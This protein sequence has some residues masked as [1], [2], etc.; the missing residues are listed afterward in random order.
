M[1]DINREDLIAMQSNVKVTTSYSK[2]VIPPQEKIQVVTGEEGLE[3]MFS[4]RAKLYRFDAYSDSW[5][6][7]GFGDVKLLRYPKIGQ[8]RVFMRGEQIKTLCANHNIHT[9][10]ELK[11]NVVSDHSWLWYTPA[12]Y[13]EG[14]AKPENLAIM[15]K[16]AEIAEQFKEV[17]NRL[18]EALSADICPETVPAG[19]Q[20][21]A[22]CPAIFSAAATAAVAN[23]HDDDDDADDD[24][25]DDDNDLCKICH[26]QNKELN[27]KCIACKS[28]KPA[29]GSLQSLCKTEELKETTTNAFVVSSVEPNTS[30][31]LNKGL[32]S[33]ASI[34]QSPEKN[35]KESRGSIDESLRFTSTKGEYDEEENKDSL[36][37]VIPGKKL[38][39]Q[40]PTGIFQFGQQDAYAPLGRATSCAESVNP[41]YQ[42]TT[43]SLS[44][45]TP[46]PQS[47]LQTSQMFSQPFS[48][49]GAFTSNSTPKLD[50]SSSELLRRLAAAKEQKDSA[51][52]E[53][54]T[55]G[56]DFTPYVVN[57]PGDEVSLQK[58]TNV[59]I[60]ISEESAHEGS[61]YS[62]T[63]GEDDK[64]ENE[65]SLDSP[66][67]MPPKQ[68]PQTHPPFSPS[69]GKLL[70]SP[71]KPFA[72]Q[73]VQTDAGAGS[74]SPR[75]FGRS[76]TEAVKKSLNSSQFTFGAPSSSATEKSS[77]NVPVDEKQVF[78][79][80]SQV[81]STTT[82]STSQP[83]VFA[84]FGITTI[85]NK[86]NTPSF[87]L[88]SSNTTG[89]SP[90]SF[91]VPGKADTAPAGGRSVFGGSTPEQAGPSMSFGFFNS[92]SF[93]GFDLDLSNLSTSS[94]KMDC[95]VGE[96]CESDNQ[97]T[98]TV[99]QQCQITE[100]QSSFS[101]DTPTHK[102]KTSRQ[103]LLW[104]QPTGTLQFGHLDAYAPLGGATTWAESVNPW[105]QT[106]IPALD[107][108]TSQPHSVL[109]TSQPSSLQDAFT[110]N[111]RPE[112]DFSSSELLRRPAANTE[113]QHSTRQ[114]S[115]TGGYN[116]A[117]GEE[118]SLQGDTKQTFPITVEECDNNM[119]EVIIEDSEE[120]T[121]ESSSY[122]TSKGKD[123]EE[124]NEVSCQFSSQIPPMR[125]TRSHP[126]FSPIQGKLLEKPVVFASIHSSEGK[127]GGPD[128]L[129]TY[130]AG[131]QSWEPTSPL[132]GTKKQDEDC[133]LVYEVRASIVD[134]EK[135]SRLWLP[136]NFFNYT[137][138][139]V[140]AGCF[141][142]RVIAK[143][144]AKLWEKEYKPRA[145]M[146]HT[147]ENVPNPEKSEN[148]NHLFGESSAINQLTFSILKPKE[149]D[150]WG[151]SQ[152]STTGQGE[153]ASEVE[154]ENEIFL[155]L[156]ETSTLSEHGVMLKQSKASK[157]EKA[158]LEGKQ[159]VT[160]TEKETR[161]SFEDSIAVRLEREVP[162]NHKKKTPK[163]FRIYYCRCFAVCHSK[164][165]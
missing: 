27:S 52:Q 155:S 31:D 46:Q 4:E 131:G 24:D 154:L 15:F 50:F 106:T 121:D 39:W 57:E 96:K 38:F 34:S 40:Q 87:T 89:L 95:F 51:N 11:P 6:E 42:V 14:E 84:A 146:L 81:P 3:V 158:N 36:T 85:A 29:V 54:E 45:E 32:T 147:E 75:L 22:S 67:S 112:L 33:A 49:Q 100:S 35:I 83:F 12:D 122:T 159:D 129:P 132:K 163:F 43:P 116:S 127:K 20:R 61:S 19:D 16:S 115:Q 90:F 144:T 41:W 63:E 23:D 72:S 124:G 66:S 138:K 71:L 76:H 162:D 157:V 118:T 105:Y 37:S 74:C 59:F 53:S 68:S 133:L 21:R 142:C 109:Q 107:F 119:D 69:Q 56:Y 13:A 73:A 120:S 7:K 28:A 78:A 125:P 99:A 130:R 26:V 156:T 98:P 93:P 10:T 153:S 126:L 117:S 140:C 88:A 30:Q 47:A 62:T 2:P 25:D 165:W 141:G 44:S 48:L 102:A 134:R 143:E 94:T 139:N 148:A 82:P 145:V 97:A 150:T 111:L 136:A 149:D 60:E 113:Q 135:A 128:N 70:T 110:S 160:W 86:T 104:Q 64:Q 103:K 1:L 58:I 152:L 77:Q 9:G 8:G 18:K 151:S 55:G 65:D 137:K 91:S 161:K 114:E 164:Q 79:A 108:D 92:G 17:F 5:K 123:D 80:S 101:F